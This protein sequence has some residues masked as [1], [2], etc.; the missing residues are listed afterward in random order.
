MKKFKKN[1]KLNKSYGP[2]KGH[3]TTDVPINSLS[4]VS[5]SG[6]GCREGGGLVLSLISITGIIVL[7]CA[8]V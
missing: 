7:L 3:H 1:C 8:S 2:V 5:Q 6:S 4:A